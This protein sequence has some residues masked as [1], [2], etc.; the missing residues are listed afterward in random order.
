MGWLDVFRSSTFE[1][2]TTMKLAELATSLAS[3]KTE[4]E[5]VKVEILTKIDSL[6]AALADVEVPAEAAQALADVTVA[7]KA[8]D[9]IVPDA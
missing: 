4:L 8:L 7:A 3:I 2:E 1:K 6:N 5:K 9:D